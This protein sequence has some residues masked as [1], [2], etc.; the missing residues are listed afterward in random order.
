MNHNYWRII[1]QL[2]SIPINIHDCFLAQ[3]Y[4][5]ENDKSKKKARYLDSV[6]FICKEKK[7][8]WTT[9]F[10]FDNEKKETYRQH[11]SKIAR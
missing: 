5:A 9:T 4:K 6:N 1:I 3:L 7:E 8:R 2:L 11:V 10:A